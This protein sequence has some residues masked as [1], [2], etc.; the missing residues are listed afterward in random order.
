MLAPYGFGQFRFQDGNET[1]KTTS[2][3]RV[4]ECVLS[5]YCLCLASKTSLTLADVRKPSASAGSG[6]K[7][8]Q[9]GDSRYSG[10]GFVSNIELRG[11][12]GKI[13]T[14]QT[15][16]PSRESIPWATGVHAIIFNH[17]HKN[18]G[19]GFMIQST[20]AAEE[21]LLRDHFTTYY[22]FRPND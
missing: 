7:L 13:G 4:D 17:A 16:G 3:K 20:V 2:F 12:E 22:F 19:Q 5:E 21:P 11:R 9:L 15:A 8:R 6:R 18:Q 14:I 10:S 1:S